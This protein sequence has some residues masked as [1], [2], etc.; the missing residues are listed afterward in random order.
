M[1]ARLK[2]MNL[3][4][5]W[6]KAR[7]ILLAGVLVGP[8]ACNSSVEDNGEFLG[9]NEEEAPSDFS[10][11]TILFIPPS[12]DY[13]EALADEGTDPVVQSFQLKNNSSDSLMIDTFDGAESPHFTMTATTC[14]VKPERIKGGSSCE[15]TVEF[16]PKASGK[17]EHQIVAKFGKEEENLGF[18]ARLDLTGEGKFSIFERGITLKDPLKSPANVAVPLVTVSGVGIG[19]KVVLHLD[20]NCSLDIGSGTASADTV[21]I[22]TTPFT[23]DG[24]YKIFFSVLRPTDIDPTCETE[25]LT[26]VLDTTP[27]KAPNS[28]TF[29]SGNQAL[30]NDD[31]PSIVV[32]GVAA[33]DNVKLFVDPDCKILSN[34][35]DSVGSSITLT[36]KKLPSDGTFTFHANVT[37]PAGNTSSCSTG[38]TYELDTVPPIAPV[39]MTMLSPA[40]SPGTDANPVFQID[41]LVIGDRVGIYVDPSCGVIVGQQ[42]ATGVSQN[43]SP[44]NSLADG[45]YDIYSAAIDPAGNQSQCSTVSIAYVLDTTPP[46]APSNIS[47]VNPAASPATDSTPEFQINGLANGFS[48]ELFTDS[49]CTSST[50][51]VVATGSLANITVAALPSDGVYN[52]YARSTDVAGNVSNCSSANA[53]Y[54][55]D[56][57]PPAAPNSLTMSVPATNTGNDST[58]SIL[59]GGVSASD[60]VRLFTDLTCSTQVG[61]AASAGASVVVTS[62]DLGSDGLT[63]FYASST[64]FAG[65]ESSCS[66][67]NVTYTLDRTPP[68][69]PSA[70]SVVTPASSP[71]FD[72]TPTLQVGGLFPGD[73]V[74]LYLDAGCTLANGSAISA[75]ASVNITSS[76]LGADGSYNFYATSMDPATNVSGCSAVSA[77]YTL[78]TTAPPQPNSIVLLSPVSTPANDATPAVTVGGVSNTEVVGLYTDASCSVSVASGTATATTINLT[79]S[80]LG[81]DGVY[82]LYADS[83]DIAGNTSLCSS[84]NLSYTLDTVPPAPPSA[85]TMSVPLTSPGNNNTPAIQISG[86]GSGFLVNLYTDAG[87]SSGAG[88]GTAAGTSII[89]TASTIPSDGL[90]DYYARAT[91]QAGNQSGCSSATVQYVLDTVPPSPPSGLSLNNPGSSPAN[92]STPQINVTGVAVGTNVTLYSNAICTATVGSA[93]S[94]GASVNVTTSVLGAD[95]A[96]TFYATSRDAAGNLSVCSGASVSYQLDTTPS[97]QPSSIVLTSPGSSPGMDNTPDLTVNGLVSGDTIRLYRDSSCTNLVATGT[98]PGTS[99]LMNSSALPSDGAYDFR[100]TTEDPA[101]NVSACSTANVTYTLDTVAPSAPSS[102]TLNAPSSSPG[103]DATPTIA[104]NGVSSSDTV[105]LFSDSSC[106][107]SRG[108][109]VAGGSSVNITSSTLPSDNTYNFYSTTTDAAGNVSACSTAFVTYILD[110]TPPSKPSGLVLNNPASSPGTDTTPAIQV[111]GVISG[112]KVDL[113]LDAACTVPSASGTAA[114][115]TIILTAA[116]L[117]SDG[118]YDFYSEATD[119]AGNPS[120]CSAATVNYVLDTTAPSPPSSVVL[121]SPASSPGNDDTPMVRI[122]GVVATDTV[123]LWKDAACSVLVGSGVAGS[124]TIDI[125]SA[126]LGGDATYGFWANSVDTAGN[127]SGCST[128]TASYVLDTVAPAKP[129]SI[130]LNSPASSPASDTTPT[131]TVNGTVS[132]DTI[133]LYKDAA[134]TLQIASGTAS[135]AAINLTSSVLAEASYTL[136]ADA[137]DPASNGSGCSLVSVNYVLDL[138]PPSAPSSLVLAN[139]ASSPGFDST[140]E[141]TINGMISGDTARLFTDS[142]CSV[143][144]GSGLAAGASVNVTSSTLASDGPYTFYA[145]STDPTG[146]VS[147]C[148]VASVAYSLDTAAPSTPSSVALKSP[149]TSPNNDNTPELTIGGLAVGD[150][151]KVFKDAGCTLQVG[152]GSAVGATLDIVL[153]ALGGDATFDFYANSTDPAGNISGCSSATVQYVLDTL[154]PSAPNPLSL[155]NPSS[156]PG[157]DQ[158]PQINVAGLVSGD[159]IELHTNASCSALVGTAVSS[160]ASV[161]I[162]S[163]SL[164]AGSHNFYAKATDPAGNVSSCSAAT[165]NYVIDLTPPA[166]PTGLSLNVPSTSPDKDTTPQ[167]TITGVVSGDT[168]KLYSDAGCTVEIGS[169][170]TVAGSINITSVALGDGAYDMRAVAIDPAGNNSGCSTANVNYTVDTIPP[171]KPNSIVL[172][173]PPS[174]PGNNDTPEVT[175][176]GVATGLD[177]RV[178]TDSGCTAQVGSATAGGPTVDITTSALGADNTYNIYAESED[179]SGNI[180]ACSTV[181]LAYVLDTVAP[182]APSVL[183]L[184]NPSSSPANDTTPEISIGGLNAGDTIRMYKDSGCTDLVSTGVA[185]AATHNLTS[186]ALAPDG[187]YNFYAKATDPAGNASTCSVA[188]IAYT[189]DTAAPTPALSITLV[190]PATSPGNDD[191]PTLNINGV[192]A[193]DDVELYTDA[194]C[195][196]LVGTGTAAG[197]SINIT[198]SA[199]GTDGLY[200][201]YAITEDVAENRSACSTA[202]LAYVLDR[203]APAKPNLITLKV[204]AS[205]P[206][207]DNTPEVTI[208]GVTSGDTISLYRDSG[209]S[210]LMGTQVSGG[211]TVDITSSGLGS[212]APFDFYAKSVDP[213]GN[214]SGCSSATVQYVRDTAA[215]A[216][217]SALTRNSP[218]SSPGNDTTPTINVDGVSS[219]D[220]VELFT[221]G[222]CSV[223]KGA[224]VSSG[225]N[226]NITSGVLPEATHTFY[227]QATDPAGNTSTCS[228]ASVA[229]QV[230]TTAP[231]APSS[232]SLNSPASSP[233]NDNTPT[234]TIDG[235]AAT[236]SVE[237]FTDAGC[238][239]SVGSGTS[240]GASHNITSSALATDGTYDF[241]AKQ[242]DPAGNFSVCSSAKVTYVL[243][244]VAP[245]APSAVTLNSP[246]TSPGNDTTPELTVSGVAS[247]DA[248]EIFSDSGC[249]A[250]LGTSVSGGATVNVTSSALA[251]AAHTIYAISTDPAG[252]PS[253][254]SS[255]FASYTVDTT[256]PS[257]PSA[258]TLAS[259]ATSPGNDT[260]PTVNVDGVSNGDTVQIFSNA[261]CSVSLG[262][263]TS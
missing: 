191:T 85:L 122:G 149:A 116:T 194:A 136:Y 15:L 110:T 114:G 125:T 19:D 65:N 222:S 51:S 157:N 24:Q 132:G 57:T 257:A 41:G 32:N 182:S 130:V 249:S 5:A 213:A 17:L 14:P 134:C 212:D 94:A 142:G 26:Y 83:T 216:A 92:D 193:T 23:S 188:T 165:V 13:G 204:P 140:P 98:A 131:L 187:V 207:N 241:Y 93:V 239:A 138:T 224:A 77:A 127:T 152:S 252:N 219:G 81:G 154:A 88:S 100:A 135:G 45:S 113:F 247:G 170:V 228:V 34:S 220:T 158:T 230:D 11:N 168:I 3:V 71:H 244:R 37:D 95:G 103:N 106:T 240:A 198:A 49:A 44:T 84:V 4:S 181:S 27:P 246:A 186:S 209:C 231:A 97:P 126:S 55:Y 139:P 121:Q 159:T 79:A 53:T 22:K 254:C 151:V 201:F 172:K 78:D 38:L 108:S 76:G 176:G 91:D 153:G 50:G 261:G 31:T 215:P 56:T 9:V 146:N 25:S 10:A 262:S 86:V 164:G 177:V 242:A 218:A 197:G 243:D 105:E 87:C 202:T 251:E 183:N 46:I 69:P 199:I 89:L 123:Q 1:I 256:P 161:N 74:T 232:L 223:L 12:F 171:P 169:G 196:S 245:S 166:K 237:M 99:L 180:S 102:L 90:Y 66:A 47:L 174:S 255:A 29:A 238:T 62:A 40:G 195:T 30:D 63:T 144:V 259:P 43:V 36:A 214:D 192:N 80:A 35:G 175:V 234:I 68:S 203:V 101:G 72:S 137:V 260:T 225:T 119:L 208:G 109:A 248:V 120:G 75:G 124:A 73:T 67:A 162:T 112:F 155:S 18:T 250:S 173:T 143:Q 48:V 233:G 147:T 52:F 179:P 221:D 16:H 33:D 58:P 61:L 189:L 129:S 150:T 229:Y 206:G 148:S 210:N 111:L 253:G 128:A 107:I 118:S 2:I 236:N 141:V 70:I 167:I 145:N 205:S 160:A 258:V 211:S 227:A 60:T 178:F 7:M 64:D 39:S 20:P 184:A 59:V 8:S 190:T 42:A 104:I 21:D 200:N 217:P 115:A 96:Y 263:A 235:L 6:Q 82:T 163:S 185:G 156:S 54:T 28:L 226:V 133:S 117:G